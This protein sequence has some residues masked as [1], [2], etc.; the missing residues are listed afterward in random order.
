MLSHR[1]VGG[2]CARR[3]DFLAAQGAGAGMWSSP[4][5]P[6]RHRS[7]AG[8]KVWVMLNFSEMR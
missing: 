2:D 3:V 5:H 7:A 1:D 4:R 8:P 6:R